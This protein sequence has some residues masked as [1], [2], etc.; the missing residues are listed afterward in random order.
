MLVAAFR[1][2]LEEIAEADLLLHIVDATHPQAAAQAEAVEDT[3]G[4]LEVE[5][6]PVIIALNKID[7]LH[8]DGRLAE[9]SAAH[10]TAVPISAL[11]GTGMDQLLKETEAALST[12]WVRVEVVI[13]YQRGTLAALFHQ[14]GM[15]EQETHTAD[16]VHI[17]G[18][19]PGRL[20][21]RF[22][23]L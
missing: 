9:L 11:T 13:P 7:Q 3:L 14:Q 15:V 1:A 6:L 20:A 8:N 18:R 17:V 16:G 10:K 2:T 19:V 5:T 23:N 4:E 21:Y 22:Q 12:T